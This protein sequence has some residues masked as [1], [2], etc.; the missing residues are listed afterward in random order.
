MGMS[1]LHGEVEFGVLGPLEVRVAGRPVVVPGVRQRALLAALLLRRGGVV[2]LDRLIDQVFGDQPPE[3]ARNALQTYVTRLR[4]A[5]GPAAAVVVTR[6]PG[7][8]LEV[9]ADAVDVERFCALLV[10]ARETEAPTA[11]LALLEEALALWRGPAYGEFAETFPR[12]EALRLQELWLA[13]RE[14]H[15]ALLLGLGRLGEAPAVLEAIVAQEPW[16][17]RAVALLVSALAQAGRTGDALAAYTGYRD[18]LRDELGLDPSP[19]LRRLEQQVL[20]GELESGQPPR[21]NRQR[22]VL[23]ARATS[24]FGRE[25]ELA[26]VN[27]TLAGGRLVTLVGPGGVGKTRLAQQAVAAEGSVWWVELAALRDPNAVPHALA[28]ALDLDLQPGTPLLD[29]LREWVRGARGLLVVDNCEHLLDAVA[30]LFQELLGVSSPLRLLATSRQ[31]LGVDGEQVLVVPPLEVPTPDAQEARTPAVQL[32]CDRARAADPDFT[33]TREVLRRVGEVCRA[34]DGLPLAI[35]LA[36]ARIGTLTVDDLADR[37]D[38]RFELLRRVH[39]GDARHHTL[40]GVVDWSFDLLTPEQQRLFLR[41]SVFAAAFDIA[42]AEAVLA[43]EDLPPGRVADLLAGLADRSMLTR[44]GHRGVGRYR[45]LETLRAYAAARLPAAEADR[46]RRCHAGFMVDLAER[47]EAG[48]Y[49]PEELAWARRVETWLDDLRAAFGWARDAGEVDLA[50]RLAAALARYAYWRVR[51][52]LLAWGTWAAAS[53]P[54]RPRLAAAVAAAAHAAWMD[55][56]LDQAHQLAQQGLTVAGG[57]TAPA[58]TAPLEALGDAA[59]LRGDLNGA[60]EAYRG[61]AALA[62][63]GDLAG[64]A[65]ATANQALVLS[66]GGDDQAACTTASQAV[67]VALA[68]A[69]PT[70]IAM[71]RFAEG[72][73]LADLDPSAAATAL[74]QARRGAQ[75]VGNRYVAG[76]ALTATVALR[77]RHGPPDQALTLFRDAVQHWRSSRNRGLI[78]TTLRNLFVLLARTGRDEAATTLAATIQAQAPSKSYGKEA[79]RIATALAAVRRRLGDAAYAQ[80]WT[81][82]TARTLEEAADAAIRLLDSGPEAD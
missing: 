7:Y 17:E 65:I 68:S 57:P 10:R 58:A 38:K 16:R 27:K 54:T 34:L 53:V 47:A 75:D 48:L 15:A 41:L 28:D 14:D 2:P 35:E 9:P 74:E 80:A 59:L 77:S 30:G 4:Q 61:V 52:D 39:G 29:D 3:E 31:R 43:D 46:F 45:M 56:R 33:P 60:L 51:P 76:T 21:A 6:A 37:L 63:P 71:A 5:L 1:R 26:L 42:A 66:Y 72:E 64:L 67:A 79:E 69:N 81:T 24:F 11:A 19:R 13:A 49:G 62:A 22:R 73:A 44:P 18:R 70:A 8:V 23:L 12:G 78:V 50:V 55:G 32:F 82:G 36:A 40:R 20:R 25:Q